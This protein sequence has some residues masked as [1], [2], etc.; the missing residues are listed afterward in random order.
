MGQL[1]RNLHAD[2]SRAEVLITKGQVLAAQ[3]DI[4]GGRVLPAGPACLLGGGGF[5][6]RGGGPPVLL[7]DRPAVE[8]ALTSGRS[9]FAPNTFADIWSQA[10]EQPLEKIIN[11]IPGVAPVPAVTH[12]TKLAARE[13]VA[14]P[15]ADQAP[16]AAKAINETS[17]K[18]VPTSGPRLDWED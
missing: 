18:S 9:I 11:N 10:K 4:D 6:G 13:R 5:W 2:G 14:P 15:P 16:E 3:G 12:D 17:K 8:R 1:F 7:A